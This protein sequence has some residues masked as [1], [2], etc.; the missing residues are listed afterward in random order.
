LRK[1]SGAADAWCCD[2]CYEK[3]KKQP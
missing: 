2:A 1:D 3:W